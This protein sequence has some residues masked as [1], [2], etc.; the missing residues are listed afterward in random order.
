[1]YYI[2]QDGNRSEDGYNDAG[3]FE[4]EDAARMII[5]TPIANGA[6]IPDVRGKWL[7]VDIPNLT[8]SDESILEVSKVSVLDQA[9]NCISVKTIL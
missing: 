6:I 7:V 5:D 2:T 9:V 4:L 3:L 8:N 1:M